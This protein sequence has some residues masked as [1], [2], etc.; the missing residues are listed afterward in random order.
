[1]SYDYILGKG[2]AATDVESFME[3]SVNAVIGTEETLKAS[4]TTLFPAV[5]WQ[6]SA[7]SAHNIPGG[8]AFSAQVS[9]FGPPGLPNFFFLLEPDGKVRLLFMSRCERSEVELVA[10]TLDL[11]AVDQ[12]TM[13]IFGG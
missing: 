2:D 5:R 6:Q 9:S 13:E 10:A 4:I 1:M 11:V 3:S 12:Q 7:V 8:D